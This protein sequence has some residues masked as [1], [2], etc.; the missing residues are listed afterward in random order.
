[1]RV[2]IL[3]EI[4]ADDGSMG[5][6]AEV[7]VFEKLTERPEDL[8][9]SIAEGKAL[10]AAI[11]QH[12]VDAQVATWAERH[13]SCEVCGARRHSKGS[14]PVIFMTLYGDVRISSPRLH[15]CPCQGTGGPATM[16]P[17]RDLIP[18]RVAPER[19]YLEARWSSLVPYAAAAGL[20]ADVLPIASGAN[21]TTLREHTLRV[22]E[23]VETEL[24]EERSC[25]IDGCRRTGPGRRSRKAASSS[26]SMAAM[27]VTGTIERPISRSSSVSRY[28]KTVTPATWSGAYL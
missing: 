12:L 20:L 1:M 11:Q 18:G 27:Y 26:A 8:G 22:A 2:K 7:A 24:E 3:L 16:S 15:R 23:R 5:G 14:H 19:L 10:T 28:L 25:F 13:R 4:I 21:A 9:L 6:A 17:L